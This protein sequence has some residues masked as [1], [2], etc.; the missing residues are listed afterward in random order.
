MFL[1]YD[2]TTITKTLGQQGSQQCGVYCI[3]Y[4]WSIL[5]KK[6]RVSGSPASHKAVANAYNP[7]DYAVCYWGDDGLTSHSASSKKDRYSAIISQLKKGKPVVTAVRGSSTNGNH[8]VLVIGVK[9]GKTKDNV[10]PSDFYIID[11]AGSKRI[12]YYGSTWSA[13]NGF[14]DSSYGL[15]YCTFNGDKKASSTSSPSTAATTTSSTTPA[16]RKSTCSQD[17][18][19]GAIAWALAIAADNSFHYG[20]KPNSQHNGCYFCGTNT[21]KGGR[22]KTGVKDYKKSYCCNPFVHAAFAHGGGEPEMLKV[23]KKGSSYDFHKGKGYDK[24]KTFKNLYNPKPKMSELKRGDVLCRGSGS[25]GPGHVALYIGDGKIVH[26]HGGDDNVRNSKKWNGSIST[27]KLTSSSY[28]SFPRVHRYIGKGGGYMTM[29]NGQ[30]IPTETTTLDMR[31]AISKLYSSDN[32][33]YVTVDLEDQDIKTQKTLFKENYQ[34]MLNNLDLDFGSKS[35]GALPEAIVNKSVEL[36]KFEKDKPKKILSGKAT[37]LLSF[38]TLVEAPTI[39]LDFNG[40]KIGGYGNTGDMYPNYITSMSVNKINGR[41]NQYTI[42]LTYQVRPG[43]DPNFIDKLISRTGYTNPLKILYGDSNFSTSYY[44]EESAVIVNATHSEDVSS[45]R[46]NYNISAISSIGVSQASLMTFSNKHTKPSTAI[47]D[48][49]YNSGEISANLLDIFPGMRDK[50]L[51]ASNNLIPTNDSVVEIGGI[52]NVSPLTYL[53][54]LV[55]CM[56]NPNNKSTYYL[57][58]VDNSYSEFNGSY[59]KIN[60]VVSYNNQ[61]ST[62]A[63]ISSNYFELDIGFPSDNFITNFQLCNDNYWPLVYNYAGSIPKFEYGIDDNGNLIKEKTS[64][65]YIDNEYLES[66]LFNSNWWKQVTEFPISAKV[67]IKGLINPAMLM[68]YV[69]VNALFYGQKDIASGLYV[70]TEQNDSISGSGYTT[71]LTLLR[72]AGE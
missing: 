28:K 26:A 7:K 5:E 42:N 50:T 9:D 57:S 30:G 55:A 58:I 17:V 29:P 15:Q 27:S 67:T 21:L 14:N 2:N 71:E 34:N 48:L 41:I 49:L 3:A 10:S 53:S 36:A 64:S 32:F 60:E 47:Y 4:G 46:I 63:S 24:A 68:S 23:C 52:S 38:P 65:L 8:Y 51:V 59:F 16:V 66:S 62:D 19:E 43:E 45:Y 35:T 40:I 69:K 72:V 56:S 6:C 1:K 31:Q 70:V 39:V 33:E 61:P 18:I 22:A 12:G 20:K 37:N 44:R 25:S 13:S 11:P 54:H